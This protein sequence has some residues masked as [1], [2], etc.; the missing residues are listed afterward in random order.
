V[1]LKPSGRERFERGE[2]W[3]ARRDSTTGRRARSAM[4]C[5]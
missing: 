2:N 1:W 3:R 5:G 4:P